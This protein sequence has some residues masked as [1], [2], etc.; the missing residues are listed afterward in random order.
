ML[1]GNFSR[2]GSETIK[3]AIVEL[4]NKRGD[5]KSGWTGYF[6]V[7]KNKTSYTKGDQ[8]ITQF[9][10]FIDGGSAEVDIDTRLYDAIKTSGVL[11]KAKDIN[12]SV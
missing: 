12:I 10:Y 6:N 5:E 4:I 7:Y 11:D 1:Q 2:L 9:S 8:P 3:N